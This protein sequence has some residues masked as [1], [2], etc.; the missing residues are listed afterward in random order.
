MSPPS[1]RNRIRNGKPEAAEIETRPSRRQSVVEI[2]DTRPGIPA[3]LRDY[4]F[5]R[6]S[7]WP[8]D[9]TGSGSAGVGLTV[10]KEIA[11]AHGGPSLLRLRSAMELALLF[12]YQLRRRRPHV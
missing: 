1:L 12:S 3:K 8:V 7:R 4:L 6:Y 5:E 2:A 11:E 10:A 9:G